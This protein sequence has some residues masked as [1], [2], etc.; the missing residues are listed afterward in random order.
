MSEKELRKIIK[1]QII[2]E[3]FGIGTHK[4]SKVK[5]QL[6]KL[7]KAKSQLQDKLSGISD[8]GV[9]E[10]VKDAIDKISDAINGLSVYETDWI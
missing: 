1:E 6:D 8:K 9:K 2:I 4:H 7:R 10:K 3:L 5:E